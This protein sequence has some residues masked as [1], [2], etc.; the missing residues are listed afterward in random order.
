MKTK[1]EKEK[2]VK[3]EERPPIV[4]VLGHVD[5][6]KT[7]LLDRIR[8]SRVQEKES[9]GITQGIGAS[10]IQTKDGKK[11]TFIDTPGHSAFSGMRSRGAHIAD[12]ALLVIAGNDGV[13]PQTKE[14]FRFIDEC[15]I[16][17][18]IVVT[19]M[20][21]P[22]ASVE[23]VKEGLKLLGVKLEGDGGKTPLVTVS[24]KE[25]KG[26]DELLE[27]I[28]LMAEVRG[29]QANEKNLLNGVVIETNKDK[30]G[31][32]VSAVIRDGSMSISDEISSDGIDVKI[33]GLFDYNNKP[34]TR[35]VPGD[36]VLV[37][38]FG[39]L[40]KVGATIHERGKEIVN[41]DK[42]FERKTLLEIDEDKIPIVIKADSQGSLEAILENIPEK[43]AVIHSGVGDVTDTD[44]FIAKNANP[45]RIFVF[46]AKL[47]KAVSNLANTEGVKIENYEIIYKLFE[48]L[49]DIEKEDEE[50]V[51]G[52]A[53][54]LAKFP[55]NKKTVAGSKIVEG[56][57]RMGDKLQLLQDDKLMGHVRVSSMRKQKDKISVAREGEEVGIIFKP[58]LDFNIGA[59][60]K[61]IR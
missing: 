54:V 10:Q 44:V 41:K 57:I 28:I 45:A 58:Q 47:P 20:D 9:G 8:K 36:P 46:K 53:K 25:D 7:T 14:A 38:G 55:F 43:Y 23:K 51:V 5:H 24:A 21:I 15:G 52:E 13:Q 42:I 59:V 19:K 50:K 3:L 18:M 31:L 48:R 17:Y 56:E 49:E 26:I 6:G 61:S 33:R 30:R 39:K 2:G 4:T 27:M 22:S 34:I 16:P 12:I 32:L 29:L 40:P 37:L 60:L 35:V 11:I 1:G